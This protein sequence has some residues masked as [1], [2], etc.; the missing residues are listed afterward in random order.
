MIHSSPTHQTTPSFEAPKKPLYFPNLNGVRFIAAFAV[1]IHHIEQA[2]RALGLPNLYKNYLINQAGKQG[3][4][5]FFVLSGFLITYL[6]LSEKGKKGEI[7]IKNFYMRRVLRI[8]PI[9][10]IIVIAAMIIFPNISFLYAPEGLKRVTDGHFWPRLSLLLMVLP[11][12]SFVFY[13]LPYMCSQTWSIGVEEQFY[14]L[15]PWLVRANTW[16]KRLGIIAIFCAGTALVFAIY[17]HFFTDYTLAQLPRYINFFFSQFRILMMVMGGV[18]AYLVYV[19]HPIL[20]FLYRKD[21]QY[22]VYAVLL[23]IIF[24]GIHFDGIYLEVL[25]VFYC[26]FIVNVATNP[27]TVVNLEQPLVS[28]L[29]KISY[30]LYIYHIAIS[31]LVANVLKTYQSDLSVLQYNLIMYPLTIGLTIAVSSASFHFLE[32]KILSFKTKFSH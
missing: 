11:N 13:E 16:T 22:G 4:G 8:W 3:V 7:N 25:S 9:Y 14:Y 5:L 15:W 17:F 28:Y 23:T 32:Q 30:G 19:K 24:T 21:V 10:F 27:N 2:K 6:L 29:G 12:M 31:I 18:G 26:F 20:Q 1:I